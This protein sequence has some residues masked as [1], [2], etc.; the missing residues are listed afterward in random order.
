MKTISVVIPT[1]NRVQE[2]EEL[3]VGLKEAVNHATTDCEVI[4]VDDSRPA[5]SEKIK[6]LC[7]SY[8][9]RFIGT[10]DHSVAR[11]RNMGWMAAKG[12]F[13]LFLDS[14]CV[15]EKDLI[16]KHLETYL[17]DKKCGCLGDLYFFGPRTIF[18][19]A[20][21]ITPFVRPFHFAR[22]FE[23]T[24]WG[25]TANISFKRSELE[26]VGGFDPT[27]P[28]RPGG[29]DVD[30]GLRITEGTQPISCNASARV[31]HS[32]STWNTYS[33]NIKRFFGWGRADY[34]LIVKQPHR[35]TIDLPRIPLTFGLLL[36]VCTF[37]FVLKWDTYVLAIPFV[38]LVL[39]LVASAMIYHLERVNT[40]FLERLIALTYILANE[41]GTLYEGF[42]NRYWPI[43]LKRM[44]YGSGQIYGEWHEAGKRLWAQWFAL[45]ICV[46]LY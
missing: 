9:F 23:S 8:G 46:W 33:G 6:G 25:P 11:K 20:S 40:P 17:E 32:T 12:S 27:F 4:V 42:T 15:P 34:H 45:A 19:R 31:G 35:T 30:L 3:F 5:E 13:I 44:N 37:L 41:V 24:T 14:D 43:V 36:T 22:R 38:W 39:T 26:R 28:D 29:E 1:R 10:D 16:T 7:H 18:F 21:E 2:C